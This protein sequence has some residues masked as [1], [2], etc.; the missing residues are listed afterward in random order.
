MVREMFLLQ[1]CSNCCIL[2]IKR[3]PYAAPNWQE[4]L[5]LWCFVA[6]YNCSG[7]YSAWLG[8]SPSHPRADVPQ[9]T[10]IF[11]SQR[12]SELAASLWGTLNIWG[13]LWWR[14]IRTKRRV[15]I[16]FIYLEIRS[17]TQIHVNIAL[18]G[19]CINLFWMWSELWSLS[20]YWCLEIS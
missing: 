4:G 17:E 5:A 19:V 6:Y 12:M 3:V 11:C 2:S 7:T 9:Y 15:K 1:S 18:M 14:P 8:F 10:V 20:P 13:F 16:G